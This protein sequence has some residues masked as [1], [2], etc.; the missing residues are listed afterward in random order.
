M[1]KCNELNHPH[2]S[3]FEGAPIPYPK[4]EFITDDDN[5][6]KAD[7]GASKV[8]GHKVSMPPLSSTSLFTFM[9]LPLLLKVPPQFNV[10]AHLV[11]DSFC[12]K[13][14]LS[15]SDCDMLTRLCKFFIY[16]W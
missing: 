15:S 1:Q 13:S 10:F 9:P 8:G 4:R 11:S 5:D 12:E 6:D 2:F 16:F 14:D 3:I 7:T